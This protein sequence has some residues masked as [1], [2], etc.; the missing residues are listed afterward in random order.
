LSVHLAGIIGLAVI[1]ALGTL[2]PI[3]LGALALARGRP[4]RDAQSPHAERS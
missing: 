3:N 2:R 4:S 1:F